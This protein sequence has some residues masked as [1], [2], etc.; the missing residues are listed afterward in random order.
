MDNLPGSAQGA[1][2]P[3]ATLT[4]VLSL[5]TQLSRSSWHLPA[6]QQAECACCSL[7]DAL[8][9]CRAVSGP[10]P[11]PTVLVGH[12][13]GGAVAVRLAASSQV[14]NLAGVAVI[15]VVEGT[16]L[17]VCPLIQVA[18]GDEDVWDGSGVLW[19]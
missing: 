18:C 13:M 12:S 16:A 10:D 1:P 7:Q 19:A 9:V 3:P 8:S 6:P 15:D 5:L 2:K 17:Q 14:P 4:S 11:P